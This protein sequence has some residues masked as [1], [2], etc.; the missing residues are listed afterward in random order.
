MIARWLFVMSLSC[1]CSTESAPAG[2]TG[3]GLPAPPPVSLGGTRSGDGTSYS[4]DG[5]GACSFDPSPNDLMVA[6]LNAPDWAGSNWCG[7]CA[8]V[9]G[10]NGSVRIRIVDECPECKSGDL[11]LSP[12]AFEKLAPLDR[13]RIS[14]SWNFV[15]CDV[16]GP[17]RYR[18]KDGASQWWTA[19]QVQNSRLPV[20][21]FEWS[22]DGSSF[23]AIN[24][25]DYNYFVD[26]SGFG[27]DPVHV[28]VTAV[29]GQTLDDALP[30]VQALLVVDGTAQFR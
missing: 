27:P 26:E 7:A 15:S 12:Q 17:V 13:G 28:R 1:A 23:K 25:T 19:V 22:K 21:K 18:F 5:S 24:R 4:A 20:T 14:I 9:T 8:D 3:D 6:A 10:P 2:P 16:T 30:A 29:G 11:D